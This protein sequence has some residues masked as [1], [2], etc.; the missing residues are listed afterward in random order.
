MANN[1]GQYLKALRLGRGYGLRQFAEM[2]GLLPS[3]LSAIE[4]G[5]RRL[6]HDPERL[7]RV[8]DALALVEGS[9]DWDRFFFLAKQ[10][11]QLP[12]PSQQYAEL[13]WFP[14]ICRALNELQPTERE[15]HELFELIKRRRKRAEAKKNGGDA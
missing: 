10:P 5:R 12:A 9:A 15:L 1:F 6:P 8:A 4:H 11:G 14:V 13:E 7:R 2:I 3:N